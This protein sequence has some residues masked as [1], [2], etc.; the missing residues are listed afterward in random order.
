MPRATERGWL[1]PTTVAFGIVYFLVL[2]MWNSLCTSMAAWH[3]TPE[4]NHRMSMGHTRQRRRCTPPLR[5]SGC[6]RADR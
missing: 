3:D 4:Q 2:G 1:R 6:R 5:P